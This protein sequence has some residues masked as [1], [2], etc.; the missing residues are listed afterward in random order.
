VFDGG[1][2]V[3]NNGTVFHVAAFEETDGGFKN[4]RLLTEEQVGQ[5]LMVYAKTYKLTEDQSSDIMDIFK[6]QGLI[7]VSEY[8]DE[9]F[10]SAEEAQKEQQENM[11]STESGTESIPEDADS[12][13]TSSDSNTTSQDETSE[14]PVETEDPTLAE[15]VETNTEGALNELTFGDTKIDINTLTLDQVVDY[16]F[17]SEGTNLFIIG[18]EAVNIGGLTLVNADG[19]ELKVASGNNVSVSAIVVNTQN[20]MF[21]NG[22]CVGMTLEAA[23][24]A[25][26]NEN[27]KMLNDEFLILKNTDNTLVLRVEEGTVTEIYLLVNE[28]FFSET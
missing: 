17:V 20:F 1:R 21:A 22:L 26:A 23:T 24:Q 11:E 19:I 4:V 16:G 27:V 10:A 18:N 8:I 6:T 14:A 9:L 12:Q 3:S 13:S 5:L 25:I 28:L 7:T 2:T 15:T